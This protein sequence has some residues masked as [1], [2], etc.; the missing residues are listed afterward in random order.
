MAGGPRS[1]SWPP[2]EETMA[3]RMPRRE[4]LK[5][6]GS[7]ALG[8]GIVAFSALALGLVAFLFIWARVGKHH[9]IVRRR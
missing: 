1:S 5:W 8:V 4:F 2:R 7:V 9:A 3:D 6:A